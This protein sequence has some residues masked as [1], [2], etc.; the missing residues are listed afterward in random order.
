MR[1]NFFDWLQR[2]GLGGYIL[3]FTTEERNAQMTVLQHDL[4]RDYQTYRFI[5]RR[6]DV[7]AVYITAVCGCV[8]LI[9]RDEDYVNRCCDAHF[10]LSILDEARFDTMKTMHP[11]LEML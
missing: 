11:D 9:E 3:K 5:I 4:I 1:N 7:G 6:R 10:M 8:Y 2:M